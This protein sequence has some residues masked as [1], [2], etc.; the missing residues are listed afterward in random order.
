MRRLDLLIYHAKSETATKSPTPQGISELE[1]VQYG[2]EAQS[3]IISLITQ[4]YPRLWMEEVYI[5]LVGQQEEYDLP[6][7]VYIETKIKAL[8]FL[9][10]S[11]GQYVRIY[12]RSFEDRETSYFANRP[13]H[14][15]RKGNTILINPPP[16]ISVSEGLRLMYQY[17][18]PD[19]D[20]R[21]G[22][23]SSVTIAGGLLTAITLNLAP[24]LA[25]DD[26]SVANAAD[27]LGMCDYICVVD[28]DGNSILAGICIDSYNPTTGVVTCNGTGTATTILASAFV[29]A[30]VTAGQ[31]STTHSELPLECERYIIRY[32]VWKILKRIGNQYE[33]GEAYKE[34]QGFEEELVTLFEDPDDDIYNLPYEWKWDEDGL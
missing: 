34:L 5:D 14:Y 20:V 1:Y 22:V 13:V 31:T 2:N 11:A 4:T 19:L 8:W 18:L 29:G 32:I 16:Q 12:P 17:R 30:Y 24:T 27:Y 15:I 6:S 21:R 25:K 28:K 26:N 33:A 9:Y 10:G 7:D 23:I 3:R